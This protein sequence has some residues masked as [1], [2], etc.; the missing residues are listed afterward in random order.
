LA[1]SKELLQARKLRFP[2]RIIASHKQNL[3]TSR[4]VWLVVP[5]ETD[6]VTQKMRETGPSSLLEPEELSL[7]PPRCPYTTDMSF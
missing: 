6:C 4:T 7:L 1:Q 3:G 5:E 2:F